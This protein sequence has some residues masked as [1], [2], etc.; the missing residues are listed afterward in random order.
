MKRFIITVDT[1]GDN[2][3]AW[4]PGDIISTNNSRFIDRFQTLCES[5]GFIPVY[6][7]S[8]E[9]IMDDHF[10]SYI[11]QKANNQL[12]E[13]G[14]HLHA[15]NSPPL[16]EINNIYGGQPYITEF[17]REQMFEKHIWLKEFITRRTGVIPVS[18]RSGRWATNSVLFSVLDE[19]GIK[20]DCSITPGITMEKCPGMTVNSGNSYVG[21][22]SKP[23]KLTE[24]LIEVPMTTKLI[25][26]FSGTSLKNK[27]GN[28]IK[29]KQFWL[30]P[31]VHEF[32]DMT[33]LIRQIETDQTP[34]LEFMIHS[35]ELMPGGSPYGKDQDSVERIYD[36]ITQLFRYVSRD[37][38]GIS[39]QDY[40]SEIIG[41][42]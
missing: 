12:C 42:I 6:L 24:K 23:Y 20:V 28:M 4:K 36:R 9:M 15:W 3:W 34:Y 21:F 2:L 30:R 1:E 7:C 35:S 37:Y 27:I 16:F 38:V 25:H 13:I 32:E 40:Y 18:Y 11:S 10:C 39:L 17:T 14:M 19:I 29:G 41:T 26:R 33:F 5:F 22:P 31:A 8:Y